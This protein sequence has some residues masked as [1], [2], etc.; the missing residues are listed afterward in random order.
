VTAMTVQ[1]VKSV[2]V[3][4]R[5]TDSGAALAFGKAVMAMPPARLRGPRGVEMSITL[6]LALPLSGLGVKPDKGAP[7]ARSDLRLQA[8]PKCEDLF[9]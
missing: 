3:D 2:S 9:F 6:G 4:S 8:C 7:G 1:N 5:D